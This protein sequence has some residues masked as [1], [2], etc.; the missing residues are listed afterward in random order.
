MKTKAGLNALKDRYEKLMNDMKKLSK[1]ELEEVVGGIGDSSFS[2]CT[3]L[4]N[5]SMRGGEIYNSTAK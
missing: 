4:E 5:F 1:E 2:N 3:L